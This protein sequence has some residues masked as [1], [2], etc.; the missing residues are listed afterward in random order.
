[1]KLKLFLVAIVSIFI[2]TSCNT[3]NNAENVKKIDSLK[4]IID[5]I[6]KLNSQLDENTTTSIYDEVKNNLSFFVEH[7]KELPQNQK[8]LK[9][10]NNYTDLRRDCKNYFKNNNLPQELEYSKR[11]LSDLEK[12][13]TNN[14]IT[15]EQFLKYYTSEYESNTGLLM[16][17][18]N[19]IE[20][21]KRIIENFNKYKPVIQEMKDSLLNMEA[22]K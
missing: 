15:N 17:Y 4:V 16:K 18:R 9:C 6:D 19:H 14:A 22:N 21:Q 8:H 13:V 3:V 10:F 20:A 7:M 1:M 2:S 11:Q 12:D 5:K